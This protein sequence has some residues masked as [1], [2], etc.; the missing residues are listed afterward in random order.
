MNVFICH[1]KQLV[2]TRWGRIL[3]DTVGMYG[4]PRLI[5]EWIKQCLTSSEM[6]RDMGH[7]PFHECSQRTPYN[8]LVNYL[9]V[10]IGLHNT[11]QK[12]NY[13][14]IEKKHSDLV[15]RSQQQSYI[16]LWWCRGPGGWFDSCVWLWADG[17][18]S[19][20]QAH[21]HIVC[22]L[23]FLPVY[24]RLSGSRGTTAK[25]PRRERI[26]EERRGGGMACTCDHFR[27]HNK[28]GGHT[29]RFSIAKTPCYT[30]TSRL[31]VL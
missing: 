1:Q 12:T 26:T 27:S 30:Q 5:I 13:L 17:V 24:N 18:A 28:D 6:S 9:A 25:R 14:E 31:Y 15:V 29:V 3:A 23:L 4:R 20:C 11:L 22:G 16:G 10:T 8:N 21:F 7:Q 2:R 19:T